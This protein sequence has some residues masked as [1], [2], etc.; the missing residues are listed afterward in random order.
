[1][2]KRLTWAAVLSIV[3][4]PLLAL[5]LLDPLEGLPLLVLGLGLGVTVRLVSRV[6]IPRFTWISSTI[7]FSLM[8]GTLAVAI[9]QSLA[10]PMRETEATVANPMLEGFTVGGVPVLILLLWLARLANLVMIAGL[11]VYSVKIFGARR[12]A[13]LALSDPN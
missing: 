11:I 13:K 7:A 8:A 2:Q 5:G 6:R 10:R 4:I 9:A 1:M 3:I 12:R